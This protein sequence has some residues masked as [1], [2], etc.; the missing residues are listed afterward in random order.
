M[1]KDYELDLHQ[2][3]FSF[4]NPATEMGTEEEKDS[5]YDQLKERL[6]EL[7]KQ[8]DPKAIMKYTIKMED[9][10]DYIW[11]SAE[12]DSTEKT[13]KFL[14]LLD[15]ADLEINSFKED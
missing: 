15:K 3:G 8:A 4:S 9:H 14:H 12:F 6:H 5:N 7:A 11:I 2:I 1:D 13:V 10:D